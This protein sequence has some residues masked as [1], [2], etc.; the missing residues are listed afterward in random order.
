MSIVT[1]LN[2]AARELLGRTQGPR[3]VPRAS[4]YE[5]QIYQTLV[6]PGDTCFDVGA[7]GG[8]VS[9]YLAKLVGESGLVM[10]FEPVWPIYRQLCR[11]VQRDTAMKAPI[12]TIPCGL[13]DSERRAAMNVPDGEFAMGSLADPSAWA[14][15]QRGATLRSYP[16]QLTT[17][18]EFLASTASR[19]PDF[20]KIDVE[21]A[22]LFVLHGAA[23]L[24]SAGH[25]PLM[26]IEVF[27]PWE[28][29]FGYQPWAPLSWLL[30]RGY[31]FM[32]ACPNGMVEHLPT[33]A[34]PFPA[35][36]EMG[37]NVVVYDPTAHAERIDGLQHLRAGARLALLP[38]A[39]PPQP[40]HLAE[41]GATPDPARAGTE[42]LGLDSP[43]PSGSGTTQPFTQ[44]RPG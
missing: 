18:D 23:E 42:L 28:R 35:N 27:A 16:V 43:V 25:R 39:P 41:P 26:L 38:M 21:G 31:R 24:F 10:A 15:A 8:N 13:A 3:E 19:D 34:T 6:R 29:A 5:E 37:Y 36:Y 44:H 22:E 7:N 32:F 14:R 11:T 9:L 20:I 4:S 40:N 33:E 12:V 17:V 2:R 1:R 30:E